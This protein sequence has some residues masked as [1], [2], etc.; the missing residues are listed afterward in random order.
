MAYIH[1]CDGHDDCG[2]LSDESGCVCAAGEL[3]CPGDLCV[4]A[5]RV[6]DG[7]P[8]CP[9]GT[10]EAVC[11]PGGRTPLMDGLSPAV[12]IVCLHVQLNRLISITSTVHLTPACMSLLIITLFIEVEHA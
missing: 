7:V 3:Q 11:P 9:S 5:E 6:C 1:R 4:P 2:D 8:D 12:H 10:D